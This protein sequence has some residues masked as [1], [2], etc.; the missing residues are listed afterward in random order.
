MSGTDLAYGA[1][2]STGFGPASGRRASVSMVLESDL[3]QTATSLR[4]CYA[5]SG[6]ELAYGL[7][8]PYAISGT[9]LAYGAM[10]RAGAHRQPSLE[11]DWVSS[12]L[13]PYA[14]LRHVR[15]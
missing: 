15:Y 5:M 11:A 7:R 4:A 2:A 14:L 10:R 8:T 6:T 1:I 12:P 3:V 9:D 13:S